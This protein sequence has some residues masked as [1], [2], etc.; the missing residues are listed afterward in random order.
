MTVA[1]AVT[2]LAAVT[3]AITAVGSV[4]VGWRNANQLAAVHLLVNS[5]A[6]K[7]EQLAGQAGF[8][9]G[10]ASVGNF[11]TARTGLADV[12]QPSRGA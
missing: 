9:S 12:V 5:Q 2:L 8:A 4:M 10:A 1:E 11:P 3:A 7:F 6:S